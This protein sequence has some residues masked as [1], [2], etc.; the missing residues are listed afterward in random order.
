MQRTK[1]LVGK[2]FDSRRV[3]GTQ[4]HAG[5]RKL[6]GDYKRAAIKRDIAWDLTPEQFRALVESNCRFCG[7]APASVRATGWCAYTYNGI[8]RWRNE[9]GYTVKN[10]VPACGTCNFLKGKLDGHAFYEAVTKIVSYS[11]ARSAAANNDTEED[12]ANGDPDLLLLQ[13]GH[14]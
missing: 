10:A 3:E 9:Q 12:T 7:S 13:K 5:F 8:D 4:G 1:G 6:L 14:T 11:M 2:K